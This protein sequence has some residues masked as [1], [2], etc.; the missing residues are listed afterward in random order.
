MQRQPTLKKISC[1]TNTHMCMKVAI[2]IK[3]G[4]LLLK[5]GIQLE[6]I[7]APLR[8]SPVLKSFFFTLFLTLYDFYKY[9]L[10]KKKSD[11]QKNFS[12]SSLLIR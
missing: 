10:P 7:T 6:Q 8:S 5:T 4:C 11:E 2:I 1:L 3:R 12:L 9:I